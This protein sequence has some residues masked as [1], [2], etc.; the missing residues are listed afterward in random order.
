M[1]MTQGIKDNIIKEYKEGNSVSAISKKYNLGFQTTRKIIAEEVPI[2][3][4]PN[5]ITD[6]K[7]D[8]VVE[9]WNNGVKNPSYIAKLTKISQS[10]VYITL[11]SYGLFEKAPCDTVLL[12]RNAHSQ[13]I[14]N[15]KIA[16]ML[17]VS[18]Q[19]VSRTLKRYNIE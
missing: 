15:I 7:R 3:R 9:L 1:E 11:H 4:K 17:G 19:Y 13:G 8:E 12:I 18:R 5:L 6:E 10:Q 2:K 16:N 14:P